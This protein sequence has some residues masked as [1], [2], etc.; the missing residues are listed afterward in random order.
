M[1]NTFL[2]CKLM[3]PNRIRAILISP[4]NKEDRQ[5]FYLQIDND[6]V[7]TLSIDH[8]KTIHN[9][10]IYELASYQDIILGHDYKVVLEGFLTV[11]LDVTNCIYFENFDEQYSYNG[12]DLG[13]ICSL[14][15]TSFAVWAPL[16]SSCTLILFDQNVP[17]RHLMMRDLHGVYRF[18]INKNLDGIGYLYEVINNGLTFQVT[19]PYGKGSSPNG[20]HSVVIDFSSI[21]INLNE[22]NL[23]SFDKYTEAIIYETSVRDMTSDPQTTIKNK[24]KFL[25]LVEHNRKTSQGH[26]IGYDYIVQS[27]VTHLQL[28]PIYDFKT[29]DENDPLKFYNWGYD[30]QQYFV[31]EGSYASDVNNPYSR[32]IDL[33]KMVAA[34]HDK[35]I[36]IVKDVV[37]NHVYQYHLSTFEKIVPGYYFRRLADG[38]ISESSMCGND[39]ASERPMVRKL[40]IDA[41]LFWVKEYGI[42]GFRFDLMGIMDIDTIKLLIK[43][44]RAIKN[45]FIFYGEG[46]DMPTNLPVHQ[47]ANINN[48]KQIPEIAFFNDAFRE[49]VK[50]GSMEDNIEN[51]GYGL[52]ATSHLLGFKFAYVGSCLDLVFPSKFPHANQSINYV[53]CHDNMTIFDKLSISNRDENLSSRLKRI[54]LLNALTMISY[55]IP[56]FHKGQEIGLSKHGDHNSYKSGDKINRYDYAVLDERY[57]MFD[58]FVELTKLRKKH[59][60]LHLQTAAEIEKTVR[61]HDENDGLLRIEYINKELIKPYKKFTIYINVNN[62]PYDIELEQPYRLLFAEFGFTKDNQ[63]PI[64]KLTIPPIVM[65]VLVV[66]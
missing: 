17:S 13:A 32:I 4:F 41:S 44:I 10:W 28:M 26:P 56:F 59:R 29:I 40:I 45:D 61:F 16:A 64:S 15:S 20:T 31:P 30:P 6:Q 53:E 65:Y 55:G 24:G 46:W 35:G 37:F 7:Q 48:A 11:P 27:G 63:T 19:D 25:G 57:H 14:K 50:G 5:H 21:N 51:R 66:E 1:K 52:G 34:F 9:G 62:H 8:V 33:K 47:K 12:D 18:T 23:P 54:K 39:I 36:R 42:D 22:N 58:Y 38:K 3:S 60:F 49:I 2:S 43:K